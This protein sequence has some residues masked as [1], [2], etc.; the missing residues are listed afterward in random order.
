MPLGDATIYIK[1]QGKRQHT[2]YSELCYII[3]DGALKMVTHPAHVLK[4]GI[5]CT[6][7]NMQKTLL[8]RGGKPCSLYGNQPAAAPDAD[9]M[10]TVSGAQPSREPMTMAMPSTQNANSCSNGAGARQKCGQATAAASGKKLF[11]LR[12]MQ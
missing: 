6:Q 7:P 11:T 3:A 2:S 8:L 9:S 5:W 10:Y 12:Q 4:H 1:R